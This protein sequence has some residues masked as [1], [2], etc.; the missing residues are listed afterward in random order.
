[1]LDCAA[2]A[3]RPSF[4]LTFCVAASSVLTLLGCGSPQIGEG[5]VSAVSVTFTTTASDPAV[6]TTGE[7]AGGLVVSR[8]F[9]SAS[10]LTLVPCD[11]KAAELV[12]P[13]RG[14]DL[15]SAPPPN[16]YVTT[17]VTDLCALRLDIDPLAQNA[18]EGVPEGASIYL[19]G[20]DAA[21]TPFTLASEQSLSLM[22][23]AAADASFG[24]LPL[25]VAFDLST[26]L[27]AIPMAEGMTESM[28]EMAIEM[29]ELQAR[30]SL[31]VYV[32]SDESGTLDEGEQ[33]AVAQ[34][35]PAR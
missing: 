30:T 35:A 17:A 27:A 12:L 5:Q 11:T 25:L 22:L 24:D 29:F 14:Y 26:W 31:A 10:S 2:M 13:P 19:E 3:P 15:L 1:M 21:G 16:E 28:T 4:R 34:P 20:T 7:P 9:L 33:T 8:V 32:D 6:A 23:E 18:A